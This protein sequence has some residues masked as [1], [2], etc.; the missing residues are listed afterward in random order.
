MEYNSAH[1]EILGCNPLQGLGVN[2][3]GTHPVTKIMEV[4]GHE[5]KI[6]SVAT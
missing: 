6:V 2:L 1:A 3:D 4:V 5:S